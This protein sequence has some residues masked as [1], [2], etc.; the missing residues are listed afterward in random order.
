MKKAF[1]VLFVLLPLASAQAQDISTLL[2]AAAKQPGIEA[3]ALA[4][5]EGNLRQQAATAALYPK[6]GA[7]G[8][9]QIYNSPTNARPMPPTEV[10]VAAGDSIPFSR[11][12]LRYGLSLDMPLFVQA[13]YDLRRK[14]A[15]L[16]TKARL[17]HTQRLVANEAAVVAANGSLQYLENLDAAITARLKS[18][19]KTREDMAQ[20]VKSGRAS[21]AELFKIE[22]SI[23]EL[24]VQKNDLKA[25]HLDVQRQITALTALPISQSASMTMVGALTPAPYLAVRLAEQ[26]TIAAREELARQKAASYPSLYFSGF[27]SGNEGEAYNTDEHFF[28]QYSFAG[29]TLKMPLFDQSIRVD[30]SLARTQLSRA[31]KQLAQSR[32]ELHALE[33]NLQDKLPVI[34]ESRRLAEKSLANSQKLLKV[35]QVA[36]DSGRTTTEEYLRYE[37]QVLAAQ[38]A[39]FQAENEKWQIISQL[40]ALYGTELRGVIQ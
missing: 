30:K 7:F 25:K 8:K 22:N 18:L 28:R 37:S 15:A 9:A 23:N 40:A 21:R 3:A 27:V 39:V 1:L 38:A 32:I 14:S 36:H 12:L 35:A 26:E 33:Q 4:A 17:G 24:E 19:A 20:K 6:L 29:L 10:N 13:I 16:A 5:K 34:T 11:Q 31:K 2:E